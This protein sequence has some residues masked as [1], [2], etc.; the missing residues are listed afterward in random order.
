MIAFVA[1]VEFVNDH[2]VMRRGKKSLAYSMSVKSSSAPVSA[3]SRSSSCTTMGFN[4]WTSL[5]AVKSKSQADTDCSAVTFAASCGNKMAAK[6][7]LWFSLALVWI[8][9]SSSRPLLASC[10][11]SRSDGVAI[12]FAVKAQRRSDSNTTGWARLSKPVMP[13][14]RLVTP[15]MGRPMR[16]W[17][18]TGSGFPLRASFVII[19]MLSEAQI[20]SRFVS[21]VS[22]GSMRR[23]KLAAALLSSSVS[24]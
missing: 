5:I 21:R 14:S 20:R 8:S 11:K 2:R 16:W 10:R 19:T 9:F 6:R 7:I 12:S 24:G 18:N 4:F 23:C 1:S 22:S 3:S 15:G 17:K 13:T